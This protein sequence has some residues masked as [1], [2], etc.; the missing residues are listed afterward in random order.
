MI[1]FG[2][3]SEGDVLRFVADTSYN[4]CYIDT[5]IHAGDPL[6]G[7]SYWIFKNSFGLT[8]FYGGDKR[9]LMQS[10]VNRILTLPDNT[11]LLSGHTEP[12]TVGAEK[13]RSWYA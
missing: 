13:T 8:H 9:T 2:T 5:I 1:G 7:H 12:T 11:I 10:V 3:I 4:D 6:I